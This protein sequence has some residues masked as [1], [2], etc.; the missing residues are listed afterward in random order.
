[1]TSAD[2]QAALSQAGCIDCLPND[3]KWTL[4]AQ[5][6]FE[7]TP[8]A[9]TSTTVPSLQP[10][11]LAAPPAGFRNVITD[12][13]ATQ[14][15]GGLTNSILETDSGI[16]IAGFTFTALNTSQQ[17]SFPTG[18]GFSTTESLKAVNSVGFTTVYFTITYQT[19]PL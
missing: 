3:Q 4:I 8:A 13:L 7:T 5:L 16:P 9:S 18:A 19:L 12:V 1:M 17:F 11:L 6:L 10:T 14:T 2:V 15:S